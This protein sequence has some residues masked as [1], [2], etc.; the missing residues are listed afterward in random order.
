[1]LKKILLIVT[2]GFL[3]AY[4][5][6][7]LLFLP[8]KEDSVECSGMNISIENN[9]HHV[10][11]IQDIER[12]LKE[13]GLTPKGRS[14]SEID[15]SLIEQ[16]IKKL[17]IVKECECY[18]THKGAINIDI[19]CKEPIMLVY[20]IDDGRF[21]IDSYGDIIEGV[22]SS[23]YLPVASG[24]I[25]RNMAKK[26][27]LDIALLLKENQFWQEQIEQIYFTNK[28]EIVFV[29]RVGNHTIEAGTAKNIKKKLEKLEEFYKKGLNKIGWNKYS[30][31]NIEFDNR[32]IGTR[33][34]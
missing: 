31:L 3:G 10:L 15:C 12:I 23:I 6:F 4:I 25:E 29:P 20:T 13:K 9:E 14:L 34:E 16:N 32:V 1:M 26:E 2:A 24:Y 5:A 30:K 11:G 19:E 18:K 21:C 8:T 17:S 28:R 22:N 27:L 7:A 33:R